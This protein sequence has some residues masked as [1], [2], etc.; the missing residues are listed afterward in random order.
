[1]SSH[2][3]RFLLHFYGRLC[4][5][6][7]NYQSAKLD[8]GGCLCWWHFACPFCVWTASHPMLREQ[9]KATF[10]HESL[11]D[12][13]DHSRSHSQGLGKIMA[14]WGQN[15]GEAEANHIFFSVWFSG[16]FRNSEDSGI[17]IFLW[18]GYRSF[19]LFK[20]EDPDAS[21]YAHGC[22]R[23]GQLKLWDWL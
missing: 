18:S 10:T 23:L 3:S 21:I 11:K 15:L 12:R 5:G 8:V 22:I 7:P 16:F 13:I 17:I 2:P 14:S 1:M 9:V 4:Q 20:A 19:Q 6:K